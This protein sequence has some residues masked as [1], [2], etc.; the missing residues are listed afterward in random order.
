M[1]T[2][3][4]QIITLSL[5]VVSMFFYPKLNFIHRAHK[6]ENSA[7]FPNNTILCSGAII[8]IGR[9]TGSA[10]CTACTTCNYCVYCNNGGSCGVCQKTEIKQP[11]NTSPRSRTKH[12]KIESSRWTPPNDTVG[13]F[14]SDAL[15]KNGQS[16]Y[17]VTAATSLRAYP[18]SQSAVLKRLAIG[19]EII[20]LDCPYKYWCKVISKGKIGWVKKHLLQEK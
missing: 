11:S 6:W 9:C 15:Q 4:Y 7:S 17:E 5:L 10:Y 18:D 12:T 8:D 3:N 13:I 19:E 16:T 14:D 2:I 1:K 20:M